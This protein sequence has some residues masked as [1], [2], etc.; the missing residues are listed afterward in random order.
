MRP[1]A[2]MTCDIFI[3]INMCQQSSFYDN[4]IGSQFLELLWKFHNGIMVG[5]PV[6]GREIGW[7]YL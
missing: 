7:H 6:S 1:K 5:C 2:D 3:S 4:V